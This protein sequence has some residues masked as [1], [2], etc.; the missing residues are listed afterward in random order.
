MYK[1]YLDELISSDPS[2]FTHLP[3]YPFERAFWPRLLEQQATQM[4]SMESA[5]VE[6]GINRSLLVI[7]NLGQTAR[8]AKGFDGPLAPFYLHNFVEAMYGREHIHGQ[9]PVKML[10][11]VSNDQKGGILPRTI[12]GRSKLGMV[13]ESTVFPKDVAGQDRTKTFF[14]R[15]RRHWPID[16]ESSQRV[17]EKSGPIQLYDPPERRQPELGP[18]PISLVNDSQGREVMHQLRNKDVFFEDLLKL[19]HEFEEQRIKRYKLTEKGKRKTTDE[20]KKLTHLRARF[21]VKH[22]EFLKVEEHVNKRIALDEKEQQLV[23]SVPFAADSKPWIE[24][25]SQIKEWQADPR[26]FELRQTRGKVYKDIDDWRAFRVHPPVLAWDQRDIDP[27]LVQDNEFFPKYPLSLIDLEPQPQLMSQIDTND[28][29]VC[30]RFICQLIGTAGTQSGEELLETLA[31][32][33]GPQLAARVPS[34]LDATTGG[35]RFLYD[36]RVRTIP[37]QTL[38]EMALALEKFPLRPTI[39]HM[40]SQMT[41][42][43]RKHQARED[44]E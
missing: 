28:K 42:I 19:E 35:T 26:I 14:W 2:A 11:W 44:I 23:R 13:F 9:G 3:T 38:V 15:M 32:G 22:R 21:Q 8:K 43:D 6:S 36:L 16:A 29:H 17:A 30:L 10:A 39:T 27:L 25:E 34:L 41:N 33:A 1:P 24:L 12:S 37:T 7:A 40:R 4:A 31:P 18:H 20:W 5:N